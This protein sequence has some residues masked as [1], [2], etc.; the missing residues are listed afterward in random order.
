VGR[1]G[2][3]KVLKPT[4]LKE[5]SSF[6]IPRKERWE[7]D[8]PRSVSSYDALRK[9]FFQTL[10]SKERTPLS[11]KERPGEESSSGGRRSFI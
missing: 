5:S 4:Q 3:E 9:N 1:A 11:K 7:R 6:I 8:G 10:P 2:R